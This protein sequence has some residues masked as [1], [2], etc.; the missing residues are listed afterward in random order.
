MTQEHTMLVAQYRRTWIW[1]ALTLLLGLPGGIL[2]LV[3]GIGTGSP[4]AMI[5]GTPL[6]ILAVFTWIRDFKTK[7]GLYDGSIEMKGITT[8]RILFDGSTEFFHKSV[9]ERVDG[10]Q[11]ATHIYLKIKGHDATIK[12]NSNIKNVDD[13]QKRLLEAEARHVLPALRE[14]L[15]KGGKVQFGSISIQ[16]DRLLK[17]NKQVAFG[18]L[19]G[20]TVWEDS[21]EIKEKNGKKFAAMPLYS[22]SNLQTFLSLLKDGGVDLL[23]GP[24]ESALMFYLRELGSGVLEMME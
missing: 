8:K 11:T 9:F 17:G 20:A 24:G 15:D 4:L 19:L 7:I 22:I 13:L 5:L 14:I 12:M 6:T 1:R 16:D 10:V 3:I 18:E 2:P 21:L 23:E